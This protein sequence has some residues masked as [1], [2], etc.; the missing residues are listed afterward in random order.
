MNRMRWY[1][2]LTSTYN[3]FY[4]L[5][6]LKHVISCFYFCHFVLLGPQTHGSL[7]RQLKEKV[8]TEEQARKACMHVSDHEMRK[9]CIFDVLETEDLEMADAY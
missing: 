7:R 3:W 9:E 6:S 5:C 1:D 2:N 8:V 4:L